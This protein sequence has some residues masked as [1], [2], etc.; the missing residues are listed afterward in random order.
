MYQSGDLAR[1]L[2]DGSVEYLG[3]ADGQ[4]K[5]R[6]LRIEL[7]E[8]QARLATLPPVREAA[9]VVREDS[10]GDKRL[11]A[12]LVP[13]DDT[14]VPDALIP[15]LRAA[16]Q[17]SLP[18]YMVPA[19][20]VFLDRLPLTANGKL[21]R[22]ALPMPDTNLRETSYVAPR[23]GTEAVLASIWAEVLRLDRVGIDD[24]YFALGGDSLRSMLVLSR[25]RE[26]GL[27]I[28]L[29]HIVKHQTVAGI[30]E[31]IT[32]AAPHAMPGKESEA[33]LATSRSRSLMVEM[34][35]HGSGLPLFCIHPVGGSVF[36]Y[37]ELALQL[38]ADCPVYGLQAPELAG[39]PLVFED[40]QAMAR[41]YA[42]A[43]RAQQSQGPYR[44]LGWSSGGLIA[45]AIARVLEE[46]GCEVEYVGVLDTQTMH[47]PTAPTADELLL[48][49]AISTMETIRGRS[50]SLDELAQMQGVL[51]RRGMSI[52]DFINEEHAAF[53]LQHLQEWIG[54]AITAESL[55]RLKLQLR[56][57]HH[58]MTL[59]AGFSPMPLKARLHRC[60]ARE[61]QYTLTDF[62]SGEEWGK[63]QRSHHRTDMVDGNHYTMIGNQHAKALA[64]TITQF[65]AEITSARSGEPNELE[66]A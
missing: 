62:T 30:A 60:N 58:H 32:G 65:I 53:A 47:A 45:M 13:H 40:V 16:L 48:N 14:A 43:I 54:T 49:A 17:Q 44:L 21:D 36:A 19:H 12:Y 27:E 8:I 26:R 29:E 11:V 15:A 42:E 20:F 7:G 61:A 22:R 25:A 41:A 57:T 9:V 28:R 33:A 5:I 51:I 39:L 4:V 55:A 38:D 18:D 3:R 34:R 23:N 6:G 56:T 50:F 66:N 31:A 64:R 24:N 59:L 52:S 63:V 10:P 37:R 2:P 1:Y 46:Q 35:A